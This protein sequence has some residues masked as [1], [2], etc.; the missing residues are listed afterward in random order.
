[1]NG[2][3]T[4]EMKRLNHLVGETTAVYHGFSRLLGISDSEMMILY[5]LWGEDGCCA[6]HE[7]CRQSG[8]SKQTLNSALRKLERAGTIRLEPG[9][10]RSK[11]VCLT[12]AGR[13]R[14]DRTVA[15]VYAAENAIFAA[16]PQEDVT[17]YLTLTDRYLQALQ[18]QLQALREEKEDAK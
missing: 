18:T 14:A 3:P 10:A 7:I 6:P 17:Q 5:T 15:Q 2:Y 16:W 1:M 8:M 13:Q 9:Q 11:T 12:E 4:H